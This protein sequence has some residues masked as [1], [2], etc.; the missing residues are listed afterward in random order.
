MRWGLRAAAAAMRRMMRP[1][2]QQ[3][4]GDCRRL[5]SCR[6][7][8]AAATGSAAFAAPAA[9]G[10]GGAVLIAGRVLVDALSRAG[11]VGQKRIGEQDAVW[12]GILY[13]TYFCKLH[14]LGFMQA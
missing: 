2:Q 9:T 3:C 12:A 1:E 8:P 6:R 7:R 10:V 11:C 13:I 14:V 4:C 5:S